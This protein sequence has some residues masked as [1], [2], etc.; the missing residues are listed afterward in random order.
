MNSLSQISPVC[1]KLKSFSLSLS[2]P[3][4]ESLG[5]DSS[6][7]IPNQSF[8]LRNASLQEARLVI[9]GNKQICDDVLKRFGVNP[10]YQFRDFSKDN[11]KE[12]EEFYNKTVD[13]ADICALEDVNERINVFANQYQELLTHELSLSLEKDKF[14][15][16]QNL[17]RKVSTLD[18]INSELL[19]LSQQKTELEQEIYAQNCKL[20]EKNSILE[21]LKTIDNQLSN[22]LYQPSSSDPNSEL[23]LKIAQLENLLAEK[24]KDFLLRIQSKELEQAGHL[25]S[26]LDWLIHH[27]Q[28]S[29]S[30]NSDSSNMDNYNHS[31]K[32]I[33]DSWDKDL[34]SLRT[35][36]L[37]HNSLLNS[38]IFNHS[39]ILDYF[40]QDSIK[41]QLVKYAHIIKILVSQPSDSSVSQ[42]SFGSNLPWL[43]SEFIQNELLKLG[44]IDEID[45][46]RFTNI[47][48]PLLSK[49]LITVS[50][51]NG[52]QSI[53]STWN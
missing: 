15:P 5:I 41:D 37:V 38:I 33:L 52:H 16:P 34:Y 13:L 23:D 8:I 21:S 46:F 11:R 51:Q 1:E 48:Y 9:P 22:S 27:V 43:Q 35:L 53:K 50:S 12:L 45:E 10:L 25:P 7:P 2:I 14:V 40:C 42:F 30:S 36:D 19:S 26:R 18:S 49:K 4:L 32:S 28:N 39:N 3:N 24:E 29:C 20:Q 6:L 31:L 44:I 17:L 47:I